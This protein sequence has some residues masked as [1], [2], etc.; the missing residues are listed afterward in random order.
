LDGNDREEYE[1]RLRKRFPEPLWWERLGEHKLL[2][3][4]IVLAVV[5]MLVVGFLVS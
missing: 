2:V 5:V 1:R 4:L 3:F